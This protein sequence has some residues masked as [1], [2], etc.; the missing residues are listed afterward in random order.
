LDIVESYWVAFRVSIRDVK[1]AA[2]LY[3]RDF[4]SQ[5]GCPRELA[6]GVMEVHAGFP[7][8]QVS[9]WLDEIALSLAGAATG[10]EQ[11]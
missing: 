4:T 5:P 6:I 11:Q 2:V 3:K 1:T 9:R 8:G 10:E 7:E